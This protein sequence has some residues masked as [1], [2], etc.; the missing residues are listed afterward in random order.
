MNE[1]KIQEHYSSFIQIVIFTFL[2]LPWSFSF[3]KVSSASLNIVLFSF[4]FVA[5]HRC[6]AYTARTHA[7][8]EPQ[9]TEEFGFPGREQRYAYSAVGF[10]IVSAS[11]T[12]Q[13]G[14]ISM[15]VPTP[16]SPCISAALTAKEQVW[17]FFSNTPEHHAP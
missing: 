4:H 11:I 3:L 7:S 15:Q 6:S 12:T 2:A 13:F 17:K 14:I 9:L 10:A 8:L 16:L 1:F 5:T